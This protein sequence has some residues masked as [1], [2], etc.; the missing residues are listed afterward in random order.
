MSIAFHCS[1]GSN[2][3]ERHLGVGKKD[4]YGHIYRDIVLPV[5]QLTL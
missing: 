2:N 1:T 4:G 5:T 3:I